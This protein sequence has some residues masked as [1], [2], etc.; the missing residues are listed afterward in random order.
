[1]LARDGTIG[2]PGET[3]APAAPAAPAA[4]PASGKEREGCH[5]LPRGV[6]GGSAESLRPVLGEG[7]LRG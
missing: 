6:R 4:A 3:E 5:R 1:M 2:P 7:R